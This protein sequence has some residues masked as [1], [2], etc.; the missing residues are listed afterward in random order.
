MVV[1]RL[2]DLAAAP[3]PRRTSHEGE[4]HVAAEPGGLREE[5]VVGLAEVVQPVV[6]EQGGRAVGGAARHAPGDGDLLA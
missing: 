6:R 1:D 3:A 2:D 5:Q 4:R